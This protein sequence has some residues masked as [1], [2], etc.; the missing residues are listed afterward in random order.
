MQESNRPSRITN[1]NLSGS[2]T[3]SHPSSLTRALLA[4][5]I[6]RKSRSLSSDSLPSMSQTSPV[7]KESLQP[8]AEPSP[9]LGTMS[10]P[11]LNNQEMLE[12]NSLQ[13]IMEHNC[14]QDI[15][16]LD[17]GIMQDNSR[18]SYIDHNSS[19]GIFE[20][21][22]GI[23]ENSNPGFLGD[24]SP[25]SFPHPAEVPSE[26]LEN[27]NSFQSP[28]FNTMGPSFDDF[29]DNA[30]LPSTVDT[31]TLPLTESIESNGNFIETNPTL[32]PIKYFFFRI[33]Q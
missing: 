5:S 11:L 20:S 31:S 17:Q 27:Q 8:I 33:L 1:R 13:G 21:N 19:Q 9:L 25:T 6:R 32:R 2:G 30:L 14:S 22:N 7:Y 29:D 18:H 16:N 24:D 4:D 28:N 15:P 3:G 23:M 26:M 12:S 10:S